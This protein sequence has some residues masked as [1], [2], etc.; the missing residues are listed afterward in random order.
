MTSRSAKKITISV[1]GATCA[2]RSPM[3]QVRSRFVDGLLAADEGYHSVIHNLSMPLTKATI[4]LTV[5]P[6]GPNLALHKKYEVSDPNGFNYGIGGLT[7][8]SWDSNAPHTFAT[9]DNAT[10][11]KTA[12]ID[13]EQPARIGLVTVGVPPFGSTKTINISVSADGKT[14]TEVGSHVFSLHKEEQYTY[15]FPAVTARYVRLTYPDHYDEQVGYGQNF[16]FTT[17]VEVYAPGTG[18][19]PKVADLM[20][21]H[22]DSASLRQSVGLLVQ[23]PIGP[24]R[25]DVGRGNQ[26]IRT[27]FSVGP[28][29]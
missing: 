12:T 25:L 10:F 11:P 4:T 17:E 3:C 14:F 19:L 23:T 15:A 7:D 20:V 2:C 8:G 27:H 5:A 28:F 1:P 29:S 6:G 9:G 26:G 22:S 13:L 18:S 24:I 16:A 21:A